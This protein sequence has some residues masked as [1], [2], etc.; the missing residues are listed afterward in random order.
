MNLIKTLDRKVVLAAPMAGYTDRIYRR[1]A[2]EYGADMVF[3][4]MVSA[5]GLCHS[6]KSTLRF[7]EFTEYEKPIGIQF[8]TGNPDWMLKAAQIIANVGFTGLDL[9]LGCPVRKVMRRGAG[10]ALLA[11]HERA[12]EVVQAAMESKIPV[13]VKVRCGV[14]NCTEWRETIELLLKLEKIGIE[15]VTIH[16]RSAE[17]QYL[18][19]ANWSLIRDAVKK[20]SIPVIGSGDIM[21]IEDV[22]ENVNLS[23][24]DG[25]AIARGGV[26]NFQLFTQARLFCEGKEIP[27]FSLRDRIET[28]KAFLLD[29]IEFRGEERAIKWGTKIFI[30]L[31]HGVSDAASLRKRLS[32]MQ[33]FRD[34]EE[35]LNDTLIRHAQMQELKVKS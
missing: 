26:A 35:L 2:H 8:F 12:I 24:V 21:T 6:T 31:I 23:D 22:F 33:T 13:S 3:T 9:N 4:E 1:Y 10:A 18:G 27:A 14:K 34:V 19:K 5:E 30:K 28:T 16:P 11:D 7:I 17:Q 15:F 20:L 25:I 29:E 32:G